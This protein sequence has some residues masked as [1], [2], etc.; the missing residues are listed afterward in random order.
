MLKLIKDLKSLWYLDIVRRNKKTPLFVFISFL[1]TFLISRLFANYWIKL[2]LVISEY[3]IHHF[4]YG[5]ALLF[6][7]AWIALVTNKETMYDLSAILLGIGSGL[8]VDEIGLLLTCTSNGK[9][10]NYTSRATFDIIVITI[11]ILLLIL[12]SG[13]FIRFLKRRI[14][15]SSPSSQS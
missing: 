4:Y 12:Y 11:G 3:H 9:I 15:R 14:I 13:P 6:I 8:V 10:C 7:S 1:I 2:S 5:F